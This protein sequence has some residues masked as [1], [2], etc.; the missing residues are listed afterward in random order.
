MSEDIGALSRE[1]FH[2]KREKSALNAK[3]KDLNS[4]IKE[5]EVKLLDSLENQGL[6]QVKSDE[7]TVY[8][9]R[10]VVPRVV[11]WEQFYEYIAKHHYF[12]LLERRA[13]RLSYKDFYDLGEQIPGVEAVVFDE[14]RTRKS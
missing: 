11:E 4:Q 14:I 9:T 3:V 12:H 2:L 5:I 10:Q 8:V 13:S 6:K 7:G 1:L